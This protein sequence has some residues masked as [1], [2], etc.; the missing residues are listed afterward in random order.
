MSHVKKQLEKHNLRP[1]KAF[2][3]N[4]LSDNNIIKK[5]ADAQDITNKNVIEIGP[6]LGHLTKELVS[7]AKK[8]VAIEIDK[9]LVPVLKEEFKSNNNFEV[10]N[11]DFLNVNLKELIKKQFNNERDVVVVANLPYYLT[12]PIILKL[13]ENIDLFMSFVLMMQKE[14]ALRLNA[15]INTKAYNNLSIMI[16]YYCQTKILFDV[17]PQSFFPAPKITSSVVLFTTKSERKLIDDKNFWKFVRSCFVNKRKTLINNLG[18]YLN[19]KEQA[20]SI[21]EK[22]NWSL[23]IRAE[24]L[25]FDMFLDL[26]NQVKSK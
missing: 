13:L 18:N 12:S 25:T 4:F 22:L 5:I 19:N 9:K 15:G 26:F 7:K 23:N 16:Q 6:G 10:I 3:Q 1:V 14:V 11:D 21:V 24:N 8:L 20:I 17:K 2:G